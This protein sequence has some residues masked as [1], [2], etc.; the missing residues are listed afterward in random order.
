MENYEIDALKGNL[1]SYVES[2]TTPSRERGKYNCPLCHSGNRRNGTGAFSIDRNNPTQWHCFSCNEGGDLFDL[3]GKVENLPEYKDQIERARQLYGTGSPEPERKKRQKREEAQAPKNATD[4]TAYINK[5]AGRLQETNYHTRRGISDETARRF[6]LG[7]DPAYN[8]HGITKAFIIPVNKYRYIAGKIEGDEKANKYDNSPGEKTPFNLQALQ[9]AKSP[10]FIVEGAIDALS[11]A[12]VGGE[13]IAIEGNSL[14][15]LIQY[16]KDTP[17]V[18]PLIIALDNDNPG[19][20]GTE[21]GEQ[22]LQEAGIKYFVY[23]PYNGRKDA[24]ELLLQDRD[25]LRRNVAEGMK[26]P[27]KEAE[28]EREEYLQT[29]SLNHLQAFINGIAES[30]NTE[31]TPTGFNKLDDILGG[32]LYEGLYFVGALPSLGKTTLVT[33]IADHIAK[34]G[35]DVLIFSLE[36]AR[37]EL[38]PVCKGVF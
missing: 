22:L 28:A 17:P 12:E 35:R 34:D 8:H 27:E 23:D 20:T 4:Y 37:A 2:I 14:R 30:V 18:Q 36:M 3:I 24:N 10:I 16:M 19:K 38:M 21:Q 5:C 7:Y 33:Q 9:T 26:L 6:N 15:Q 11:I 13:A 31:Y 32:G 25:A 1:R 29:A